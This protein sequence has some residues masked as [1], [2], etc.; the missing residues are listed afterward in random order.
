[1]KKIL[2]LL[3]SCSTLFSATAG[4]VSCGN[5]R[6]SLI[7]AI[8]NKINWD[9]PIILTPSIN[10][11]FESQDFK[12]HFLA[13][14]YFQN[15]KLNI[16][17]ISK[18]VIINSFK[19][20]NINNNQ[21]YKL[22][23][24]IKIDNSYN[25]KII[26]FIASDNFSYYWLKNKTNIQ[27][28]FDQPNQNNKIYM[29]LNKNANLNDQKL[30][31]NQLFLYVKNMI[32]TRTKLKKRMFSNNEGLIQ[33]KNFHIFNWK[34]G[35][36]K[37]KGWNK[38]IVINC[39]FNNSSNI[40]NIFSF[41]VIVYLFKDEQFTPDQNEKTYINYFS[42]FFYKYFN[43][44]DLYSIN[45]N[46]FANGQEAFKKSFIESK[47][48]NMNWFVNLQAFTLDTTNY[49]NLN[50]KTNAWTSL[51]FKINN[52]QVHSIHCIKHDYVKSDIVDKIQQTYNQ[53][54][55]TQTHLPKI[56]TLSKKT[57]IININKFSLNP[58]NND[59]IKEK[60]NNLYVGGASGQNNYT[61]PSIDINIKN[62]IDNYKSNQKE[63][64]D[65][66]QFCINDCISKNNITLNKN[67]NKV[68][69]QNIIDKFKQDNPSLLNLFKKIN[70]KIDISTHIEENKPTKTTIEFLY[71]KNLFFSNI[72]NIFYN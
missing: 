50:T 35:F 59:L 14:L 1:M 67:I 17:D 41:K 38:D 23:L 4:V 70:I 64:F 6:F 71:N 34:D 52:S 29:L 5:N 69:I 31:E 55:N 26:N 16:Q 7:A 32:N 27:T 11:K 66:L 47:D 58:L 53:I 12:S 39:G 49:N 10:E 37:N 56:Y 2:T 45:K 65:E 15:K 13:A 48:T 63:Y 20:N 24:R 46:L 18:M 40:N 54:Y 25:D 61:S 30:I 8:S 68:T 51:A 57:S 36:E 22:V 9:N 60:D 62:S 44:H 19:I 43:T 21:L 33:E 3:L 28:F 72:I 42:A